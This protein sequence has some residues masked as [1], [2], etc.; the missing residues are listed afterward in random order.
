MGHG[1][2]S[3]AH[4]EPTWQLIAVAV[5]GL[6]SITLLCD[7]FLRDLD[8]NESLKHFIGSL[9][10]ILDGYV[11]LAIIWKYRRELRKFLARQKRRPLFMETVA[12]IAMCALTVW[13]RWP[14]PSPYTVSPVPQPPIALSPP[15]VSEPSPPVQSPPSTNKAFATPAK[16]PRPR[17]PSYQAE[18][19]RPPAEA[20]RQFVQRPSRPDPCA[21]TIGGT[22]QVYCDNP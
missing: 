1:P 7:E 21:S 12:L 4:Q 20:P 9:I 3:T 2:A 17:Y 18:R 11:A 19:P 8:I 22:V 6:V 16:L 10:H 13:V 5:A 14:S 15:P